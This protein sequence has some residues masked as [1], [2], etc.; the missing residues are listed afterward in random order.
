MAFSV[1]GVDKIAPE[2]REAFA[3]LGDRAVFLLTKKL[4]AEAKKNA[5]TL[6]S[7]GQ[8]NRSKVPHKYK[9]GPG[10]LK[11]SIV[12]VRSIKKDYSYLVNARDWRARFI[13]FGTAAHNMPATKA[14]VR[15][16]PYVFANPSNPGGN[17]VFAKKIIHPGT[18][19]FS[20]M[21]RATEDTVVD[22]YARE[23]VA[24]MNNGS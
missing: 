11:K 4:T 23:V 1:I 14:G 12:T 18:Q 19:G 21:R 13:E 16:R 8:V 6:A 22:R 24:E 5:P 15:K 3:S 20:Y 2:L 10:T 17:P 7:Y 9:D